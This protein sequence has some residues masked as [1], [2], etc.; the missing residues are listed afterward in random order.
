M[1]QTYD[2]EL[3][4]R[5]LSQAYDSDLRLRICDSEFVIWI[6]IALF[7]VA[8]ESGSKIFQEGT[9]LRNS[10]IIYIFILFYNVQKNLQYY[11]VKN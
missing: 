2:S 10:L 5:I 6:Y 3:W 11:T 8:L 9:P 7:V 4:L 1:A